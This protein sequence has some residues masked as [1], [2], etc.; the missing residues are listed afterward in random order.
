MLQTDHINIKM[1]IS[2]LNA[3]ILRLA[4][5]AQ[6]IIQPLEGI[7]LAQT[8]VKAKNRGWAK[9]NQIAFRSKQGIVQW[10]TLPI[11]CLLTSQLP[12]FSWKKKV[13][14]K[15][16]WSMKIMIPFVDCNFWCLW[17]KSEGG[18]SSSLWRRGWDAGG[19]SGPF[20]QGDP[21]APCLQLHQPDSS[22]HPR[23]LKGGAWPRLGVKWLVGEGGPCT[24]RDGWHQ[25]RHFSWAQLLNPVTMCAAPVGPGPMVTTG[26]HNWHGCRA[27]NDTVNKWNI[28]L[29]YSEL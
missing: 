25:L 19:H 10:C 2:Q 5:K 6:P 17:R 22:P 11:S 26:E 14:L 15:A 8:G 3:E 4:W 7:I 20:F 13:F 21:S 12:E 23:K 24:N 9:R 29:L 27:M 1:S 28:S 16:C 18:R